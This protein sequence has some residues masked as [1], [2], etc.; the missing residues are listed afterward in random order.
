MII[1]LIPYNF[2]INMI[3]REG[4]YYVCEGEV[5]IEDKPNY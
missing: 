3:H 5:S 4:D 2:K 1:Q